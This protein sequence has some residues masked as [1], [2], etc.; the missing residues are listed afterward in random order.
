VR[1]LVKTDHTHI[2]TQGERDTQ[3]VRVR[4]RE[5]EKETESDRE[6]QRGILTLHTIHRHTIPDPPRAKAAKTR[7]TK[8]T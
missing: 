7:E 3:R 8:T 6:R 2:Y 4:E 1:V 5:R